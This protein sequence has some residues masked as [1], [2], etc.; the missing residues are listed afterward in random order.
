[1][2]SEC[3]FTMKPLFDIFKTNIFWKVLVTDERIIQNIGWAW[4]HRSIISF[5]TV[6]KEDLLLAPAQNVTVSKF[7]ILF[8][9]EFLLVVSWCHFVM[10]SQCQSLIES[11]CHRIMVSRCHCVESSW[12]H[13]AM[14]SLC[15]EVLVSW[16]HDVIASWCHV[17]IV[18]WH[19]VVLVCC[20]PQ[21]FLLVVSVMDG[22]SAESKLRQI[23]RSHKW[24]L[25][26]SWAPESLWISAYF[27]GPL[28]CRGAKQTKLVT[29]GPHTGNTKS[30]DKRG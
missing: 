26:M 22:D 12:C 3:W 16:R 24:P 20:I 1:M 30:L 14:V 29:K 25:T 28:A 6:L 2:L 23:F 21:E 10:E 11:W 27:W 19:H 18:T 15:H 8:S 5:I 9:Q 7:P 13:G 17:I 4:H